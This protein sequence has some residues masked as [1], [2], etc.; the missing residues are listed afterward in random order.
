MSSVI[1]IKQHLN[2]VKQTR[3]ITNAMYLLSTS[4]LKKAMAGIDY[5]IEYMDSLRRTMQE[6]LYATK[7]AGIH[8]RYIDKAKEGKA[9]FL[10]VMGDKGLCG[11]YNSAVAVLTKEKMELK[12][13]SVL[14]CLGLVGKEKLNSRG[15][16][17]ERVLPGSSMHPSLD[18]ASELSRTLINMY[19]TDEINEVYVVYT[20]YVRG[21][22][23]PACTRLLPLLRHD[24]SDL[25][26]ERLPG[27]MIYE[28]SAE[29]VFEHLVPFYCAGILFEMLTQSAAS[30]NA[31]RLEAMQ[32]ATENADEM[33]KK[34]S[35][36]LNAERQLRITS[37]IAEI[38]AAASIDG[39]V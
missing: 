10:S 11:N 23:T 28:P 37:E 24:F 30:E 35:A 14:Y 3:Q 22:R 38:A 15:L 19:L 39:G 5:N 36:E 2:S 33:I 27:E 9:L 17:P 34:L 4:R 26:H 16:Y 29:E 12:K 32:A 6:I 21:E 25:G 31:A 20:P 1:E 13:D 8:N 18:L 7:G